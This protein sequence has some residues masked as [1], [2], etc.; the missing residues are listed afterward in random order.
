MPFENLSD[1]Q[2]NVYFATGVQDEVLAN[3]ARIA[4]LRVIS[5]TSVLQYSKA[6]RNLRKIGQ[7]L[8]VAHVVDCSVQRLA[9]RVRVNAQL[10][11]ARTHRASLGAKL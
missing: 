11:N 2:Q 3:L 9:N 5:R 4:D 1:D 6:N 7:Q 8:G 10:I